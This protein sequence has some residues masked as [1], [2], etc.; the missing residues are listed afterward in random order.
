MQIS[1][2]QAET[3]K[4]KYGSLDYTIGQNDIIHTTGLQMVNNRLYATRSC[5][6]TKR[7]CV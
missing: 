1:M 6:Y 5:G 4:V 7:K 3:Y 2:N